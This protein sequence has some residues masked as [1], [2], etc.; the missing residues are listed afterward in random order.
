MRPRRFILQDVDMPRIGD[1]FGCLLT[2]VIEI[3]QA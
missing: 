2:G 1:A 3:E